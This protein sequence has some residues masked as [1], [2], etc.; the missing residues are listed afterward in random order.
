M[1]SNSIAVVVAVVCL[2]FG[3]IIGYYSADGT[4]DV[5]NMVEE[6]RATL[7]AANENNLLQCE[8]G[9]EKEI[10]DLKK[11]NNTRIKELAEANQNIIDNCTRDIIPKIEDLNKMLLD[12]NAT[13]TDLNICDCNR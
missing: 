11:E 13:I 12:I 8:A 10:I 2:I 5:I 6:E 9:Y 3:G 7:E 4:P 1:E